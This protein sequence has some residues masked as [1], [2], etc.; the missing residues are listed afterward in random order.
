[1]D[2]LLAEHCLS[3]RVPI[4]NAHRGLDFAIFPCRVFKKV[5]G[6]TDRLWNADK[7]E[8]DIDRYLRKDIPWQ[9][10]SAIWRRSGLSSVGPWDEEAPSWQD[11]EFYLRA[12]I[13]GA[14]YERFGVHDLD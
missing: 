13:K 5:P 11:W 2:D 1:S 7:P 3:Q 6:D 10:A 12:L 9:T 4:M 8:N 14:R